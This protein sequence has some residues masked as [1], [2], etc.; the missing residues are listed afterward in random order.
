MDGIPGTVGVPIC[1][2]VQAE[3]A[4][5]CCAATLTSSVRGR[6]GIDGMYYRMYCLMLSAVMLGAVRLNG[7]EAYGFDAVRVNGG[8]TAGGVGTACGQDFYRCGR[9]LQ[10]GHWRRRGDGRR[11]RRNSCGLAR[12]RQR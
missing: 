6:K 2:D 3:T 1:D 11:L 5:A 7:G 10:P 12:L 8:G 9:S 4:T